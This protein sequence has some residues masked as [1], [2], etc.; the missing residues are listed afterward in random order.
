MAKK[1]NNQPARLQEALVLH[2]FILNLFGC[3]DLEALS[4]DLKDPVLEGVDDE[5]VSKLYYAMKSHLFHV[6]ISTEKLLEY[7][8]NIVRHTREINE[9]RR[10]K[11]QWK[12][13]QYLALLFTEIYLDRYFYNKA[14][15]LDEINGFLHDDFKSRPETWHGMPE[16]TED[17]LN[18]VAFWC[19]TGSGK[20][21]MM[22]INIKQYL[23][24][25]DKYNA[26][27]LNRILILTP[28]EGL[29]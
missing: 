18:K 19:A 1:K 25:A 3:N 16:F 11:I 9:H 26:K 10:E 12:Y 22:H 23:Y 29:S 14:E 4:R 2:K 28:N 5:G 17:D 21:L 13:F 7:D 24:Y 8:S 6:S 27:K 20:T 15:L